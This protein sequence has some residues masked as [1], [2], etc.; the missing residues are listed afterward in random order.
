MFIEFLGTDVFK[1]IHW[2]VC[3]PLFQGAP[4]S[5]EPEVVNNSMRGSL[6]TL[7]LM[8]KGRYLDQVTLNKTI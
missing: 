8:L 4:I 6:S 7:L 3:V 1:F 2:F 5:F